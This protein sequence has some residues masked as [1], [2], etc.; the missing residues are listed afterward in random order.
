MVRD[1][2]FV[3]SSRCGGTHSNND[4]SRSLTPTSD[5]IKYSVKKRAKDVGLRS[6]S[7]SVGVAAV[8]SVASGLPDAS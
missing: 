2:H 8:S 1:I 6:V 3:V 4:F 5:N 7:R